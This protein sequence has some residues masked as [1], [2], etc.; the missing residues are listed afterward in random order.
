MQ[1][2]LGNCLV[3][4]GTEDDPDALPIISDTELLVD[5][6]EVEVH[7]A[8]VLSL[9]GTDLQVDHDEPA[10]RVVVEEQVEEELLLADEQGALPPT[11][12]EAGAELSRNPW[13][14]SIRAWARRR[15]S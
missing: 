13:T 15:S 5:C 11:E 10:Q 1:G 7:L 6:V 8:H 14:S 9:E 4:L 12:G 3:V 2:Q